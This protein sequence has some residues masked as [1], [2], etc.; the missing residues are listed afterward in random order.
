MNKTDQTAIGLLAERV[1]TEGAGQDGWIERRSEDDDRSRFHNEDY[2]DWSIH[3]E[4]GNIRVVDYIDSGI[5]NFNSLEEAKA[6]IAK[7]T[8]KYDKESSYSPDQAMDDLIKYKII[9]AIEDFDFIDDN[10]EFANEL[11][12]LLSKKLQ[13]MVSK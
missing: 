6:Y 9:P 10:N 11:L 7:E 12:L 4:E 2:P 1:L 8:A 3:D 13:A 5:V